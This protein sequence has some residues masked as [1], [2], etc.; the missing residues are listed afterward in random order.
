MNSETSIIASRSTTIW[1]DSVTSWQM[2]S[3]EGESGMVTT[4]MTVKSGAERVEGGGMVGR[5]GVVMGIVG[6]F[7]VAGLL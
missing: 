2:S 4:T 5:V 1:P 3:T 7:V 6:V